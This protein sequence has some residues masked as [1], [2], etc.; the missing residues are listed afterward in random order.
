MTTNNEIRIDA[1]GMRCPRPI[2]ELAKAR[3]QARPGSVIVITA[4]DLA[5]ESDVK[6]WCETT[7]NELK[8]LE[9]NGAVVIATIE[10]M[11][12]F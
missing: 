10:L 1:R 8:N 7:C 3:R 6:A 9:K 2:V 4:D 12:G 5:F 11:A